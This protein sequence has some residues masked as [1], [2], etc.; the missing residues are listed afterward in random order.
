L[1]A[2]SAGEIVHALPDG[3]DTV[4]ATAGREFS[5]GQR[6]RLRLVRALMD[7]PEVLI[8]IDPTSAVDA[9][10]EARIAAGL[11]QLRADRTTL[12]FSTSMMLL[13]QA[14]HVVLVIDGHAVAEGTHEALMADERYRSLVA[15]GMAVA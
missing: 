4:I 10:T 2:S 15:R 8:L 14:D 9:L 5:G 6:Q 3:L 7:D 13:D 12:V 11:R 1:D